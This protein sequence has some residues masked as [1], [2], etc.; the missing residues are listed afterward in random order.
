VGIFDFPAAG[1]C[2]AVQTTLALLLP[3]G[4]VSSIFAYQL[5]YF[6]LQAETSLREIGVVWGGEESPKI[7]GI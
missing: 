2:G 7:I 4:A 6:A 5:I 1:S 3:D